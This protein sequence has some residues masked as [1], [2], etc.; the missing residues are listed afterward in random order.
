MFDGHCAVCH[1]AN[2]AGGAGPPLA[3]SQFVDWLKF[4]KITGPDL[5]A[6]ISSQ[7]PY[8]AP[9]SLKKNQY[10]DAFAYILEFNHYPAGNTPLDQDTVACVEMLPYP[11]Q[12]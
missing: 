2:L 3:G 11:K 7:M 8:D 5:F 4:T 10:E 6:F 12:G 9:G 1:Q